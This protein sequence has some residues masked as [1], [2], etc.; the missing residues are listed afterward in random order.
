MIMLLRE[1][2][3]TNKDNIHPKLDLENPCLL[4]PHANKKMRTNSVAFLLEDAH[5]SVKFEAKGGG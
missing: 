1:V 3:P 2:C 4:P 5:D